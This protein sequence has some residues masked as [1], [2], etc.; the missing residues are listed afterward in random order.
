MIILNELIKNS[1]NQNVKIWR[2]ASRSR[3]EAFGETIYEG[4]LYDI[5][6]E[7]R[8]MEVKDTG[9]SLATG[10]NMITVYPK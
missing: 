6:Q 5:P 8:E 1:E 3:G 4:N 7:L 9:R 10:I 2:V